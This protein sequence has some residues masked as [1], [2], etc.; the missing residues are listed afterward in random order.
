MVSYIHFLI[1]IKDEHFFTCVFFFLFFPPRSFVE[2]QF[3]LFLNNKLF[4]WN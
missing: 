2:M 1:T 4:N 3:W